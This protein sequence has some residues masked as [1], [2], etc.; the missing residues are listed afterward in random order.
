MPVAFNFLCLGS[1]A[2]DGFIPVGPDEAQEHYRKLQSEAQAEQPTNDG[3]HMV[4][5]PDCKK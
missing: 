4:P 3:W 5:C 1:C 2:G